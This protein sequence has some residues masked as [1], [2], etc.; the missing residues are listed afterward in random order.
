MICTNKGF[1]I[2]GTLGA[3]IHPHTCML[4]DL[5]CGWNAV[6]RVSQ[7]DQV[8]QVM[9]SVQ[10]CFPGEWRIGKESPIIIGT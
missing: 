8:D 5:E 9:C 1:V 10:Y 7:V 6:F 4:D 3:Y 2:G